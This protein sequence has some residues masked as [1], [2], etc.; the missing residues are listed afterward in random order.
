MTS[1]G[2]MTNGVAKKLPASAVARRMNGGSSNLEPNSD[3][4][5]GQ[6]SLDDLAFN[7]IFNFTKCPACRIPRGGKDHY[8]TDCP[9]LKARGYTIKYD[10]TK[11][12][13]RKKL[14]AAREAK[15]PS[16]T[17]STSSSARARQATT[18]T[19]QPSMDKE[20]ALELQRSRSLESSK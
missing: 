18:E 1:A 12:E 19:E 15:P 5:I 10:S 4:W 9:R 17:T 3:S 20:K 16:E 7:A 11:D 2:L 14:A 8:L 13:S 6:T